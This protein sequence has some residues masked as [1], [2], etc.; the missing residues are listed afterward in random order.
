VA[1]MRRAIADGIDVRGYLY[2]S[3]LDNYEWQ[4]GYAQHSG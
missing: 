4:H 3:A 1:A 2:W